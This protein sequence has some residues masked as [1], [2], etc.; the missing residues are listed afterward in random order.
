MLGLV[1]SWGPNIL[2]LIGSQHGF[3]RHIYTLPISAITDFFKYLYAFELLYTSAM[4]SVKISILLFQYRIFP[5]V[6]YRRILK[7]WAIF[8]ACLTTSSIL[9]CIFQCWPISGFWMTFAGTFPG[10]KCINVTNFILIAGSI[11]AATDFI[12][13]AMVRLETFPLP[14]QK[15][16]INHF[17][18]TNSSLPPS[19]Q[20]PSSGT[21]APPPSKN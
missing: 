17:I 11:N 19:S 12:L 9:V 13:L 21:S 4:A 10:A 3:G 5:I 18:T 15:M 2:L 14:P 20:S 16:N 7:L 8:I 1:F 6:Q